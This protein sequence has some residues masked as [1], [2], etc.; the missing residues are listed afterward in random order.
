MEFAT[1]TTKEE[2][3]SIL[4][5]IYY[6]YRIR[7]EGYKDADLKELELQKMEFSEKTEE[8]L[9]ELA[10]Q[11]LQSE[12]TQFE[13]E[14]IQKI[15]EQLTV[16]NAK[17]SALPKNKSDYIEKI[18]NSYSESQRQAELK[19]IKNGLVGSSII[20]DKWTELE[21]EKNAKLSKAEQDFT[22]QELALNVEKS[23]LTE[24]LNGA[25]AYCDG[26]ANAKINAK[27]IKLKEEQEKLKRETFKYNNGVDEKVQR[28]KNTIAEANARLLLQ[29]MEIRNGEFTK[30][31]LVDMGYYKRALD[32][33]C[34]Y[35]DTLP[36]LEAAYQ[37]EDD[38]ELIIYLDDTYEQ[39]LYMYQ[40]RALLENNLNAS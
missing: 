29:F 4:Q 13:S 21:L 15:T 34:S 6:Y 35:Y 26:V 16:V 3:F 40:Q 39:V 37:V 36:T 27:K 32:C 2:M 31:E 22:E 7:R 24:R 30:S 9:L 1:P 38:R 25:K 23:N 20:L 18:E 28:Y 11:L 14:Y 17:L 10:S 8:Q 33:V 5:D 12:N 19:G